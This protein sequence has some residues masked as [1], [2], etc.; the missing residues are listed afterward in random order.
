MI[1]VRT[2]RDKG[3]KKWSLPFDLPKFKMF[4]WED[5]RW[6]LVSRC[7]RF[8]VMLRR[9]SDTRSYLRRKFWIWADFASTLK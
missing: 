1:K 8:I 5:E 6:R 2:E 4:T 3:P 9:S 7:W